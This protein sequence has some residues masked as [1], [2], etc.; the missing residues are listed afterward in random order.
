MQAVVEKTRPIA[1]GPDAA[2]AGAR[3]P[4]MPCKIPCLWMG[5]VAAYPASARGYATVNC[6]LLTEPDAALMLDT[7]FTVHRSAIL[8]GVE[9]IIG[10]DK[11]LTLF[12]LRLN[13]LMSLS[14]TMAL[15]QRFPVDG[16]ISVLK[17]AAYHVDLESILPNDI[18]DAGW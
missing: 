8:D 3:A 12:P 5:G 11:P 9:Q 6:Y 15:A 4:S 16:C 2:A 18:A 10:R 17:D 1:S 7:G 13:E 14:N